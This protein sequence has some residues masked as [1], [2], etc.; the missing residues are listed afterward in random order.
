MQTLLAG[1]S[2]PK[3]SAILTDRAV[4]DFCSLCLTAGGVGPGLPSS[5]Y[6]GLDAGCY[7]ETQLVYSYRLQTLVGLHG[8]RGGPG[9]QLVDAS[10]IPTNRFLSTRIRRFQIVRWTQPRGRA[11]GLTLNGTP[12]ILGFKIKSYAFQEL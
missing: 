8:V 2:L 1:N 9:H 5:V 12:F 6:G 10:V 4:N 7:C 3:L 11:H